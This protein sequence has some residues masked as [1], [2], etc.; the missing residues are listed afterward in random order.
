MKAARPL[1]VFAGLVLLWQ[2][3]VWLTDQPPYILPGPGAV[4]L[5][6]LESRDTILANAGYTAAEIGL[7][8]ALGALLGCIQRRRQGSGRV[9]FH[10]WHDQLG[11]L[12]GDRRDLGDGVAITSTD[13]ER[14]RALESQVRCVNNGGGPALAVAYRA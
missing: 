6:W 4:V 7:G 3:F 14:I 11:D 5:A 13:P 1:I 8:L 10:P 9:Y 2:A 12:D